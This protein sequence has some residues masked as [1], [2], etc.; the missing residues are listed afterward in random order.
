MKKYGCNNFEDE[1]LPDRQRRC[2][3]CRHPYERHDHKNQQET[4]PKLIQ[5]KFEIACECCE[6]KNSILYTKVAFNSYYYLCM[7]CF[8]EIGTT[9]ATFINKDNIP[10]PY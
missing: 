1:S 10:N 7:D 4:P 9:L 6:E 2:K 5:P 8:T 3:N